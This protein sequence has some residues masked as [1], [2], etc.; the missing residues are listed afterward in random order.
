[1]GEVACTGVH[2]AN[3]LASTSLLEGLVWGYRAAMHIEARLEQQ[4][5]PNPADVVAHNTSPAQ[6]TASAAV[7][8][9]IDRIKQLMWEHVGLVRTTA[10]LKYAVRELIR[11]KAEIEA[12]YHG[13]SPSDDLIGL[14]NVAQTALLI[15]TAALS[16]KN[17]LG[18]HYRLPDEKLNSLPYQSA[19]A[20]YSAS[21]PY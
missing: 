6:F 3:R 13:Y 7:E 11:L 10:G 4:T 1:V 2:G 20:S 12:L 9:Q 8:R 5:A 21:L 16:N 15:A 18:C 17:S 19:E 14:R